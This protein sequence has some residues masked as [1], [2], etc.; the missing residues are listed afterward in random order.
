MAGTVDI[1]AHIHAQT[2]KMKAKN[3]R[4]GDSH[5]KQLLKSKINLKNTQKKCVKLNWINCPQSMKN[6]MSSLSRVTF[7][8]KSCRL[9]F[10]SCCTSFSSF[11]SS[12]RNAALIGFQITVI[13]NWICGD[14][15]F[16][17][18][19]KFLSFNAYQ[20][21]SPLCTRQRGITTRPRNST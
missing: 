16:A 8:R 3:D 17:R 13:S 9:N 4:I 11:G 15:P 7:R 14:V 6:M 2:H 19:V 12:T 10:A 1:S 18:D 20:R 5:S 21:F